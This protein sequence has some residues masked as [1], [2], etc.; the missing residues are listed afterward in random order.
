M[1]ATIFGRRNIFAARREDDDLTQKWT[2]GDCRT[3]QTVV[4]PRDLDDIYACAACSSEWVVSNVAA[5]RYLCERA[6]QADGILAVRQVAAIT[7]RVGRRSEMIV[8]VEIK[9]PPPG[10]WVT[11]WLDTRLSGRVATDGGARR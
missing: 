4:G 2:C 3:R 11:S 9:P 1:N 6:P 5:G 8:N 7:E 10:G